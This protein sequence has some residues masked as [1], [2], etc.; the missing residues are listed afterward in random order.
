MFH[1]QCFENRCN[2]NKVEIIIITI[3]VINNTEGIAVVEYASRKKERECF[4]IMQEL[5]Q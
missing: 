5:S 2:L 3:I 1:Y 4:K